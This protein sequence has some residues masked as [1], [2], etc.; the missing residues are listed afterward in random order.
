MLQSF[1]RRSLLLILLILFAAVGAQPRNAVQSQIIMPQPGDPPILERITVTPPVEGSVTVIGDTGAVFSNAFL[2]IRN[3]YTG[4]TVYTR[5]SGSG[6]FDVEID[7]SASTP[8]WISPSTA[9]ISLARQEQP[10][11]LPG[12]PGVTV[13]GTA[14]DP[15]T[16]P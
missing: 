7:A 4:V 15:S 8:F 3:L 2:A 12:G 10:G 14:A 5:A 16:S 9:E 1:T 13:Y 6:S 11:I